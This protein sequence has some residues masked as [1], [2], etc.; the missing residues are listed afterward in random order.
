MNDE[1]VYAVLLHGERVGSLQ[2]RGRFTKFAFDRDYWDRPDRPVLGRWFEDHPRRTPH[3]TNR[4]PPWFSNL[5]PEGRLRELIAR[6][7]GVSVHQEIDLLA[8][9]GRDL[10]GAQSRSPPFRAPRRTL[11]STTPWTFRALAEFQPS[12]RCARHWRA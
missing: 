11:S 1:A 3:A 12:F 4:V 6:E 7:Q 2:R 5:L 8:R 9:V 10:P